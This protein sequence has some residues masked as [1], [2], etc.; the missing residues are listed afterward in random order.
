MVSGTILRKPMSAAA[1]KAVSRRMK[2]YWKK[3]RMEAAKGKG[4][5]A[6]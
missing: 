3:R 4:E 1:R 5:V 2:A 6:K